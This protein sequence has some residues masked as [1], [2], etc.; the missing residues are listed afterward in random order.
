MLRLLA[1]SLALLAPLAS[2]ATSVEISLSGLGMQCANGFTCS[3][4]PTSYSLG[5]TLQGDLGA[6][7][8]IA[9]I[10]GTITFQTFG[11]G[12]TGEFA[13]SGG[14]IDLKGDGDAGGITS[15]FELADGR[16]LYFADQVILGPANS[17]DGTNLYL[18]GSTWT[19]G[20]W[21]APSE[22]WLLV[23]IVGTVRPVQLSGG[24]TAIPEPGSFSLLA[25]GGLLV[26]AALRRRS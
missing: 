22:P 21:T 7:Q 18:I 13:V 15:F 16:T 17:F 14:A 24:T 5:G 2:H 4:G 25:A 3:G 10:S 26:G 19:P 6:D 12:A 20:S 8:A 11:S 1:I 9:N 23:G